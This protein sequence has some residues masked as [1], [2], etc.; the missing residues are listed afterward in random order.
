MA[1]RGSSK[2]LLGAWLA[3]LAGCTSGAKP[4]VELAKID[5][6]DAGAPPVASSASPVASSASKRPPPDTSS[7]KASWPKT[8]T[9]P[10]VVKELAADCDFVPP[11]LQGDGMSTPADLFHCT[12][13]YSQ[14][15][16][17]DPCITRTNACETGCTKSCVDCGGTC[18]GSCKACKETCHDDACRTAC[19]TKCADC[20]QTCG[21]TMDRCTSADCTR[22]HKSCTTTLAQSFKKN[23]CGAKCRQYKQCRSACSS[24]T[25]PQPGNC[26]E[27]CSKTLDTAY[28]ACT[29]KCTGDDHEVCILACLETTGCSSLLCE[30]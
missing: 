26:D 21:R 24:Q 9:D 28:Q 5:P 8:W 10:R 15:C 14:S 4:P 22:A 3:V 2:V 25:K 18:A 7:W 12:V 20:K 17:V 16:V 19:A 23:G 29:D 27:S 13:G 30:I 11:Q 6:V 1:I